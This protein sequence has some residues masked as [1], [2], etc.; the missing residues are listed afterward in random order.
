MSVRFQP[1]ADFNHV[2]V[3]ALRRREPGMDFRSA[4]AANLSG[5]RDPE[6][7]AL[8]AKA[9]RIL[10]THDRRTIPRHFA[11]FIVRASSTGVIVVPQDLPVRAVVEDLLLVWAATDADE[12]TNRIVVLPL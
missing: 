8:S 2:I 5:L 11:D 1:D 3:K 4:H 9:G 10:V 12:W 7:L 6:V